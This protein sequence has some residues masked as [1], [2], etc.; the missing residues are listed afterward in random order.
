MTTTITLTGRLADIFS[1]PVE[2]VTR[3]LVKAPSYRPGPGVEL[4]TTSPTRVDMSGDGAITLKVVEG[5]GW[6]YLEGEGWSDSI[7]FVAAKGMTTLWEA[8]VNAMPLDVAARGLLLELGRQYE[9]ARADLLEVVEARLADATRAAEE[10]ENEVATM[11]KA[12][13]EAYLASSAGQALPAYLTQASLDAKYAPKDTKTVML[14]GEGIDPT[15]VNDSTTAVQA[16]FEAL[17]DGATLE[18]PAGAVFKLTKGIAITTANLTIQGPG[19]FRWTAGIEN[20]Y[21]FEVKADGVTFNA[22]TLENP[23]RLGSNVYDGLKNTGIYFKANNGQVLGC[24]LTKF[25][26]GIAVDPG[27]STVEYGGFRLIGNR[28]KDIVGCG[29][30]ATGIETPEQ[31]QRAEGSG[32]GITVW[33]ASAVIIGNIVNAE[34]GTDARV[35]IHAEALIYGDRTS[36]D[37]PYVDSMVTIANNIV[38]GQFRRGIVDELVNECAITG[39]VIADA[40]WWG[41]N[42]TN[43]SKDMTVTSNTVLWTRKDTDL[44]GKAWSPRR[45]PLSIAGDSHN[46][47]VSGNVARCVDGS[48][49]DGFILL[50]SFGN[51]YA[52]NYA[53]TDNTCMAE[54]T[55]VVGNGIYMADIGFKNIRIS[56]NILT[57][58]QGTTY[59]PSADTLESLMFVENIVRCAPTQLTQVVQLEDVKAPGAII[60]NNIVTSTRTDGALFSLLNCSSLVVTGNS[61]HGGGVGVDLWQTKNSVVA[62]N[63]VKAATD[64]KNADVTVTVAN[65]VKI[66]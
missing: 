14:S 4:T 49:A 26:N 8:V 48:A 65:N 46:V 30:G 45:M 66:T 19:T 42:A 6:L 39:N 15:G 43:G 21:A 28:I 37:A 50:G 2:D 20:E 58:H 35:G 24:T 13:E 25:H 18:L 3:V 44:H 23:N 47:V 32:D 52:D 29:G 41:I 40:T 57:G 27:S 31:T 36:T 16:A 22:V 33:G 17:P 1:Q 9:V 11:L 64:V 55:A 60:A 61:L 53:V 12:L 7:R 56:G 59:I 54:G 5:V 38:Y 63:V 10:V 62:N 34:E 51:N